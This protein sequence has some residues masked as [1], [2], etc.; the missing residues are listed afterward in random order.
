MP[1]VNNLLP[2]ISFAELLSTEWPE[3]VFIE[4]GLLSRGDSM[5][6]GAESKAGKSTLLM[7]LIR[8]LLLGGDFL[9]FKVVK[10]IKVLL[11]QAEIRE[12][13]LKERII[14]KFSSISSSSLQTSY[15]WNTRG[16]ILLDRDLSKIKYNIELSKPDVLI[17]DPFI[18]FH[19]AS[20]NDATQITNVFRK[21]D[22]IKEE[23]NI[24]LIISQHF[25]KLGQS[26]DSLLESIR[27]STAFRGWAVTTI[28]L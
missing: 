13:R 28:A 1:I 5:M 10:P 12:S 9:G 18:N 6:I 19:T 23:F 7:T 16:Q 14:S 8:Q 25:R 20:E 26:K 4:G 11:M 24:A 21:L 17:L 27:G 15:T 3:E 22:A 2:L